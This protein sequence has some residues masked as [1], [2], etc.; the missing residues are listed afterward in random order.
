MQG[1]QDETGKPFFSTQ[2]LVENYL[3]LDKDELDANAKFKEATKA[4]E[5][6][7]EGG[8]EGEE[9]GEEEGGGLGL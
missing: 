1:L 7:G 3:K 2:W 6:G 9:G 8:K 5:G 4:A